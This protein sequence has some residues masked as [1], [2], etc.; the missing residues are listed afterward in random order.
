MYSTHLVHAGLA[1]HPPK[2][3]QLLRFQFWFPGV[4]IF[5]WPSQTPGL[6]VSHDSSG[7]LPVEHRPQ[8][9]LSPSDSVFCCRRHFTPAEPEVHI[10]FSRSF[11]RILW[12]SSFAVAFTVALSHDVS[13]PRLVCGYKKLRY[14]WQT[15][16]C[17]TCPLVN[18]CDL[19]TEFSNFYLPL[20]HLTP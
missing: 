1:A 8:C 14:H 3:Y 20:F 15:A 2:V 10:S 18:D 5:D 13:A 11:P 4:K 7:S 16:W 12:S 17:K 6:L 19:L 9:H